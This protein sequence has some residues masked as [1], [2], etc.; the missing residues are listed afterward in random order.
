MPWATVNT[1]KIFQISQ[2]KY[3]NYFQPAI[4]AEEKK[5]FWVFLFELNDSFLT[6]EL[7]I[8]PIKQL[9]A[10]TQPYKLVKCVKWSVLARRSPVC[11]IFRR[12]FRDG[13]LRTITIT[14]TFI[15]CS[16]TAEIFSYIIHLIVMTMMKVLRMLVM[17]VRTIWQMPLC[18]LC[19][20]NDPRQTQDQSR[21]VWGGA[22]SVIL[23]NLSV[24]LPW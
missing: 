11:E 20:P 6:T 10:S 23:L 3:F 1:E 15:S 8:P 2:G 19:S 7:Y 5:I 18:G 13:T 22:Q 21:N 24:H 17:I 4:I 12:Q 14:V 16:F 9:R